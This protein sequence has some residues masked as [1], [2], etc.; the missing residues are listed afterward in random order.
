M[1]TTSYL[2]RLVM[3][4]ITSTSDTGAGSQDD[5]DSAG[6]WIFDLANH[7]YNNTD[8]ITSYGENATFPNCR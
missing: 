2:E 1:K 7:N 3:T 4:N 6:P 8:V 5:R